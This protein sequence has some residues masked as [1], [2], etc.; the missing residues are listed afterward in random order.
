MKN[1]PFELPGQTYAI[2]LRDWRPE[3]PAYIWTE[4]GEGHLYRVTGLRADWWCCRHSNYFPPS[5]V[6][7][8]VPAVAF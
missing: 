5:G 6:R 3:I 1:H 8:S 7:A 2:E 4:C